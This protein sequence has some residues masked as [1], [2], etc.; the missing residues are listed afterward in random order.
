METKRNEPLYFNFKGDLWKELHSDEN[1]T[2]YGM[3]V[4][5]LSVDEGGSYILAIK[6]TKLPTNTIYKL[7]ETFVKKGESYVNSFV[8]E[9]INEFSTYEGQ[10]YSVGN[11]VT[12][13]REDPMILRL[14]AYVYDSWDRI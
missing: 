6:E 4:D 10:F 7:I 2:F 8:P 3:E 1:T 11:I 12:A 14:C 9:R 13:Y 5:P